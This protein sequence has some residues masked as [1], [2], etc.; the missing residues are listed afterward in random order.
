MKLDSYWADTAT[1]FIPAEVP[2]PAKVDVAIVG[3]GFTGLSAALALAK[4][5]A[6]VAVL[7]AGAIAHEASSRNGGHVNN[8]L[9]VDYA[10]LAAKVGSER[11]SGWYRAYDAAVDT[12]ARIVADEAID[13]NFERNGKLK[14][15]ARPAHYDTL[16]RGIERLRRE[17]DTGVELID[18]A[19]IRSEVDS[20]Q[21]CGGLLL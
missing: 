6:Q 16:A 14:L 21:F 8:G 3:G 18:G 5:G 9:A 17:V 11:A 13:C 15:A 19:R 7:E 10:T 12:V 1:A 2:L 20:D 4:R